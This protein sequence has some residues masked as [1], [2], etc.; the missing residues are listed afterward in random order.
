MKVVHGTAKHQLSTANRSI[1][2]IL[3]WKISGFYIGAIL[4]HG[5]GD[6][7]VE[8]QVATQEPWFEFLGDAQHVVCHEHLTVAMRPGADADGGDAERLRN[9]LAQLRRNLFQHDGEAA[10]L[11]QQL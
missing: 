1:L 4:L 6:E 11:F 3:V 2:F 8:V 9:F 10:Q 7:L 5:S